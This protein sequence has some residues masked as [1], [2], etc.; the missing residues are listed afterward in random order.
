MEHWENLS[1][2]Q[3]YQD[4]TQNLVWSLFLT[5]TAIHAIVLIASPVQAVYKWNRRNS[6]DGDTALPYICGVVGSALWL[7]YSMYIGEV[8]LILLQT[9]AVAMQLGFVGLL[10]YYRTKKTRL[11]RSVMV[12]SS[13]ML[14]LF[15]YASSMAHEDGKQMIGICASGAQIAGSLV[16]PYLVY[17]AVKT[18]VIDFVPFAP[19]AFTWVMELHAIVYSIGIND[20]YLLL[21]NGVFCC[22]D[23]SL[24]AMFFIYPTERK[25]SH[26]TS[27]LMDL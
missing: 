25:K 13:V 26:K 11:M 12:I 21:A 5:S 22:M 16:C 20:F 15:M 9:Y 23:G 14:L 24:L 27:K 8:K 1:L 18:K 6:S 2:S 19:V 4:Y 17:R 3:L 7:R 10:I